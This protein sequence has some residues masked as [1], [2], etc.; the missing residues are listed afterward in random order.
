MAKADENEGF[1]V[2]KVANLAYLELSTAE[3][4]T[5]GEQFQNILKYVGQLNEV[6][7][8]PQEAKS[9]GAFHITSA[10]YDLM[11][12][13]PQTSL[14]IEESSGDVE[15]LNLTNEE[16]LKNAP[17]TGGIPGELLYEVPSIIER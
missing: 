17:Q 16:A 7:M 6:A 12:V 8:S 4:K 11:N 13:D 2:E 14:R 3:I 5:F 9:M 1:S 10:F 15:K